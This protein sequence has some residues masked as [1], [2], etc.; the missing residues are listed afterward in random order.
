[1]HPI[2]DYAVVDRATTMLTAAKGLRVLNLGSAS[3]FLHAGLKEVAKSVIGVDKVQPADLIMDL[4][5][6]PKFENVTC[7]II[8]AGE[9]IEHLANPGNLLRSLRQLRCPLLVSVPNAFAE[10]GFNCVAK[11]AIEN[12]NRDHVAWYSPKTLSTLLSRYGFEI[13]R[14]YWY[15]GK[16]RLAEGIIAL[17]R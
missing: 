14:M 9:I 13:T 6:S 10:H 3:G 5:D 7:D 16:P 11:K 8:I 4:D 2:A 12:V 15:K 1:M 17:A